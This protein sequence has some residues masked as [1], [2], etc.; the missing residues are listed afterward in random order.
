M[1]A[2]H[3]GDT[4]KK[5]ERMLQGG[6]FRSVW[7]SFSRGQQSKESLGHPR[8]DE[9]SLLGYVR[10]GVSDSCLRRAV[11]PGLVPEIVDHLLQGCFSGLYS[12]LRAA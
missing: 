11:G 12:G 9:G 6:H 10:S 7:K 8:D 1:E 3:L 2:A 5:P 4:Q